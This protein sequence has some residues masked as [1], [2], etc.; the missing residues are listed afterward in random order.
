MYRTSLI[1][2][3]QEQKNLKWNWF[4]EINIKLNT[5]GKMKNGMNV[6]VKIHKLSPN[7]TIIP[8]DH[9]VYD[10]YVYIVDG[11]AR[12]FDAMHDGDGRIS[13]TV[14]EWKKCNNIKEI[15][16]CDIF[17]HPGAKLGDK[18]E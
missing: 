11:V 12:R 6:K 9:P 17:G 7:E 18:F 8:D 5:S 14:G 10:M 4:K 13:I 2:P 16:K 3:D 15:R 1:V